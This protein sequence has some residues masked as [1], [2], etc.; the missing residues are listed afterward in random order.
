MP[1]KATSNPPQG[2]DSAKGEIERSRSGD[3]ENE[4]DKG[5]GIAEQGAVAN[6]ELEVDVEAEVEVIDV[7]EKGQWGNTPL[8]L[9]CQQGYFDV[10]KYLITKGADVKA[11][12]QAGNTPLHE[13]VLTESGFNI[14]VHLIAKGVDCNSKDCEGQ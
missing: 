3:S 12:N 6:A 2:K 10:C 8:H 9:A 13:A 14:T 4:T 5:L 11:V 1:T 7:N